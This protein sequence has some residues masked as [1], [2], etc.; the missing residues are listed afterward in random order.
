MLRDFKCKVDALTIYM[1]ELRYERKYTKFPPLF[2]VHE[3]CVAT[4]SI[5]N[6]GNYKSFVLYV[7]YQQ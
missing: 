1:H 7:E 3:T 2:R 5:L 6:N 4:L